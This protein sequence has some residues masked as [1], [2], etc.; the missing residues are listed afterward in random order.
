M[1][2]NI[3]FKLEYSVLLLIQLLSLCSEHFFQF[4]T[5]YLVHLRPWLKFAALWFWDI[6]NFLLILSTT[7]CDL[8]LIFAGEDELHFLYLIFESLILISDIPQFLQ[9]LIL[10]F[11]I[12]ASS[13][14]FLAQKGNS[15]LV[16]YDLAFE[17][18][19]FINSIFE[20]RILFF[21]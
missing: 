2:I 9:L 3:I 12:E 21:Y 13:L 4:F 20:L 17:I 5:F 19:P 6:V 16:L 15:W 11:I 8:R 7:S 14:K 10:V 18:I 1:S